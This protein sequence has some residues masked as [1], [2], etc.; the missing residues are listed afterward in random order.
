MIDPA[1]PRLAPHTAPDGREWQVDKNDFSLT[2]AGE[3]R[4]S[5]TPRF[6]IHGT[7]GEDGR[8]QRPFRLR[9]DSVLVVRDDRRCSTF[10]KVTTKR[11]LLAV[12]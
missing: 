1:R 3:R 5:T 9:W 10:D 6:W 7:P 4:N 11:T 8:L 12:E 2:V